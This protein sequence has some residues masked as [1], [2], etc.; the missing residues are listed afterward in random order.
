MSFIHE[1]F[2]FGLSFVG[3]FV[4]FR[5]VFIR[6]FT[7]INMSACDILLLKANNKYKVKQIYDEIKSQGPQC[8]I[9]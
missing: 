8:N 4:L 2:N 6:D 9:I 7:I 5:S 3:R 1:Y